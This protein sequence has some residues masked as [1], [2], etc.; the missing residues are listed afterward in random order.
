MGGPK[1]LLPIGEMTFLDYLL[2]SLRTAGVRPRYVV[3]RASYDTERMRAVCARGRA[4]LVVNPDPDR[5]MLSSIHACLDE[6]ERAEKRA[7]RRAVTAVPLEESRGRARAEP[8]PFRVDALFVAPVD[9]PRVKPETIEM[10]ATSFGVTR[11]PIVV[12]R[13]GDRR[14]HPT[15]FARRL[16]AELRAAPLD[17]GARAVVRAHAKDRLEVRVNDPAVLDDFDQPG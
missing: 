4:R 1:A 17:V 5:G 8:L 2:D 3:I 13:Y 10:L 12:P 15:L 6:I 16:F 14:G 9:C 11:S 7:A